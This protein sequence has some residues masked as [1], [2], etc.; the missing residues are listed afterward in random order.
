MKRQGYSGKHGYIKPKKKRLRVERILLLLIILYIIIMGIIGI[1]RKIKNSNFSI[2]SETI[3][4]NK[5]YFE[6]GSLSEKYEIEK[7]PDKTISIS[8]IGDIMCHNTQ[9]I[10]ARTNEGY[11]FSYV[12]EDIKDE[13][14]SSDLAIGNL[15]T[16]FA[17]SKVG[18]SSY[19]TFNTPEHLAIDLKEMG[20]DLLSTVNNHCLDKGYT[21]IVGTI[22]EL[23][24]AG[25]VHTGTYASKEEADKITLIDVNGMKVAVVAYTYGTN[26]IPI[27]NGK[28]YCVNLIDREKI[29]NDLEKAKNEKPD[30]I[31]AIMHWG[32]EYQKSPNSEQESLANFLFENGV[33]IILGGH[34]HVLQKMEKKEITYENGKK[35]DGFV[36]YSLGNFVS[37]QYQAGTRQSIILKLKVTKKGSDGMIS[38]DS[39]DYTPIY[40]FKGNHY[41]ILDM[42]STIENYENGDT[43]Y[44]S[45]TISTLRT[46]LEQVK[47]RMGEKIE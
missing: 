39:V 7:L 11:D 26:G 22:N 25:I 15:E 33:D 44:G 19:P 1:V 35:K 12:F 47:N 40:T 32:T 41:R 24:N 3:E 27:P 21:G 42:Q 36:I 30:L 43:T 31:I 45:G 10:D 5:S 2:I 29:A 14:E 28:G 38:I 46:E 17:G 34:P 4:N 9:Y 6:Y 18:Y 13:I 20:I 37:G 23:D 16:T 8:V